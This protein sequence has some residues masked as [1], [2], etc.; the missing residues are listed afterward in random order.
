MGNLF[1]I[2]TQDNVT[3]DQSSVNDTLT[4]LGVFV[5]VITVVICGVVF[6]FKRLG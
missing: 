1:T 4:K 2:G 6:I 3:I 5:I